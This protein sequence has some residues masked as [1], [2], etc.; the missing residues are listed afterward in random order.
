[1]M[2]VPQYTSLK[3]YIASHGA[4]I[5]ETLSQ[6]GFGTDL[7]EIITSLEVIYKVEEKDADIESVLNSIVALLI[8]IPHNNP[9]CHP[10]ISAF[11]A[12]LVSIPQRCAPAHFR[13][14]TNLYEGI[15]DNRALRYNVFV[16][17]VKVAS[18]LGQVKRLV[19]DVS[20]VKQWNCKEI[21]LE[22][23]QSLFRL[24]HEVLLQNR[25]SELAAQ[26]MVELLASYTEETANQARG[27]AEKCIVSSLLDPNTFLLDHLLTLKPVK[28]LEGELIHALLTIFVNEKLPAYLSFYQA[29]Q[30]FVQQLGLN[31]EQNLKKMRLLT[32]M[33]M[34]E[35]QKE[36]NF[37]TIRNELQLNEDEV[38]GFVIDILKTRLVKAKIDQLNRKVIV[39]STMHRTFG[40]PQWQQ[41][42]STLIKWQDE[43][44][45]VQVT[46]THALQTVPPPQL[47]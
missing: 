28:I 44:Q 12:K 6:K 9:V 11:C 46:I 38:E 3:Q 30:A 42:K 19:S 7:D 25:E 41:L 33:Q 22:Q 23:S 5:P 43:L 10:L 2:P 35:T 20:Q 40:K 31:H 36:M 4:T 24:L 37:D 18:I 34:S 1:M 29:N 47:N 8:Q 14:L 39:T 26:V 32:F 16:A 15:G 17:L 21:T 45:K 27:D 13:V